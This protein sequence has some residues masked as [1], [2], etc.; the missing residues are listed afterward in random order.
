[1]QRPHRTRRLVGAVQAIGFRQGLGIN[2][3]DG[4]DVRAFLVEGFDAIEIHLYQLAAGQPAGFV[5]GVNIVDGR[6]C[7]VK[8]RT[9]LGHG[10]S[11]FE[12]RLL[13]RPF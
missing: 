10:K 6:F 5:C 4:I 13:A 9:G 3:Y 7:Q 11:P 12:F 1:M 2:G 8:R